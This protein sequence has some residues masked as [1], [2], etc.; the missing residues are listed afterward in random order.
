MKP[1]YGAISRYGMIAFAS[2]LDQA[3]PFTRDVTDCALLLGAM[4]GPDPCDSTSLGL[5]EPI[6]RPTATDL[7]GIRLGV[8]EELTG[9]GIEPGVLQ[10]FEQTLEEARELGASVEP[11]RLPHSP[12]GLAAYYLIAPAEC[13]S[14]LARYDGVRYGLRVP[15]GDGLLGMYTATREQGFGAEVKRR[16][17]IGTYALSSGY[18]DAYY[19]RAQKV[20]TLIARDFEQAWERFDFIVTP[21]APGVAFELGAKTADPLAM[22]LNDA[23]TVPMSLAGIP[24]ISIPNGLSENL[25]VG[26]QIAGPAFSENRILDAAHALEQAIGF[27]GS[28]AYA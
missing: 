21:T 6:Q 16:V 15:N 2:S 23:C 22:Y 13:S 4:V 5:P 11:T 24:A 12:H 18:Y 20:R 25:P 14:N 28:G 17:L 26:F 19:A 10:A 27:D 1:T 9:E 3:G 8:P 7:K